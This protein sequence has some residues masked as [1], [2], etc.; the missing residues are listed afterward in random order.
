MSGQYRAG[1]H[2]AT[3]Y[4]LLDSLLTSPQASEEPPAT[5]LEK[6]M[7]PHGSTKRRDAPT[8][9]AEA[10]LSSPGIQSTRKNGNTYYSCPFCSGSN[11]KV[12]GDLHYHIYSQHRHAYKSFRAKQPPRPTSLKPVNDG[13]YKCPFCEDIVCAFLQ[14]SRLTSHIIIH[15]TYEELLLHEYQILCNG[16]NVCHGSIVD[17]EYSLFYYLSTPGSHALGLNHGF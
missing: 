15:H 12:F 5:K 1:S 14:V 7:A 9:T 6:N 17:S 10:S 4:G 11:P 2:R 8:D 13:K 3:A 16:R